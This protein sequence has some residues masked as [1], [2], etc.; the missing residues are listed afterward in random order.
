MMDEEEYME[1]ERVI[2]YY[3]RHDL[4]G[5]AA[6]IDLFGCNDKIDSKNA[7]DIWVNQLCDEID[8]TAVGF[9]VIEYLT[10]SLELTGYS[11]LQL[12]Q[13]SSITGHFCNSTQSAYI[14]IFS[15]KPFG[16]NLARMFCERYFDAEIS[17]MQV[18]FRRKEGEAC[19]S[20]R[21]MMDEYAY[22]V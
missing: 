15:C 8:M 10:P 22:I 7:L 14:D 6:H 20:D 16:P 1:D 5:M 18:T 17:N 11:L 4:W 3:K 12:I 21:L 9:P 13:T 19:P 2:A